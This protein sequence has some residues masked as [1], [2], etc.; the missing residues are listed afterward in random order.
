MV[1][2]M[3]PLVS[4]TP[5]LQPTSFSVG[6]FR[7]AQNT[8]EGAAFVKVRV[9]GPGGYLQGN[10]PSDT[11]CSIELNFSDGK[12]L[13]IGIRDVL[14]PNACEL[15]DYSSSGITLR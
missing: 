8:G 9:Q 4:P 13:R 6:A 5:E 12:A 3:P 14:D 1:E 11:G 2:K 10:L 15:G 7:V